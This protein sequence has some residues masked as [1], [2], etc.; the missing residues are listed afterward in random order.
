MDITA[1]DLIQNLEE[2]LRYNYSCHD[3]KH[4]AVDQEMLRELEILGCLDRENC[5]HPNC[6]K[7]K[8]LQSACLIRWKKRKCGIPT[9]ADTLLVMYSIFKNFA[10]L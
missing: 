8:E 1:D 4:I 7:C 3:L 5:T 10:N 2:G 9:P 6:T